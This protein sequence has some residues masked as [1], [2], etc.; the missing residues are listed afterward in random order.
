MCDRIMSMTIKKQMDS[1]YR[2]HELNDIPWNRETPPELLVH[3][4]ETGWVK[5]CD[6]VDLGCGA[7]NYALW[8]ASRNFRMTGIDISSQAIEL[9]RSLAERKGLSCHFVVGDVTGVIEGLDDAFDFAYDWS[10]MHHVFPKDRRRYA[11]NVHRMLR[12]EGKY[13]SVCFSEE[14]ESF[15]GE[16]K[17]RQTP[18]GT[19]LYFSSEKELRE[20]FEPF[21]HIE[22][23][24][25][26]EVVGKMNSH[27]AVKTMMVK[28]A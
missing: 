26:V 21:F 2:G 25:T 15:G 24:C 11:N 27:L 13:L 1:I 18:I 19:T 22:E 9:A 3:L 14:D 28:K 16:G 10:V 4:V 6:A 23:M 12:A 5:P 17:Y 7:G 20:L 8:L